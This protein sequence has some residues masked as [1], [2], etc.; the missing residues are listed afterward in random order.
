MTIALVVIA[1]CLSW[2]YVRAWTSSSTRSF[3]MLATSPPKGAPAR[4]ASAS[5]SAEEQVRLEREWRKALQQP[6]RDLRTYEEQLEKVE[7]D[8]IDRQVWFRISGSGNSRAYQ[9][10]FRA[11]YDRLYSDLSSGATTFHMHLRF[12]PF[13][14]EKLE[15][16]LLLLQAQLKAA[17][18]YLDREHALT[19][20]ERRRLR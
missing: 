10:G 2:P 15:E 14:I 3:K 17:C 4:P 12:D 5:P 8:G 13:A 18:E 16:H 19:M 7:Q 1:A 6:F 9:E 11:E 20:D